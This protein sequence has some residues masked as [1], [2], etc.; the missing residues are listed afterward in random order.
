MKNARTIILNSIRRYLTRHGYTLAHTNISG[1]EPL[2]LWMSDTGFLMIWDKICKKTMIDVSRAYM[3]YQFLLNVCHIEGAAAEI[4]VW[5]GGTAQLISSLLYH[6][7][8]YLFDTFEG[9]PAISPEC[10][11]NYHCEGEFGDTSYED[12]KSLFSQQDY[13]TIIKGV[14]PGSMENG[15]TYP[16]KFCFVHVDVDLYQSAKDCCRHFY[17]LL[18]PGGV[19]IFDDYGFGTCPGVRQAVD[20]FFEGKHGHFYLPTG[21][22]VVIKAGD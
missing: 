11:K 8:I 3:I 13:V 12:V 14:F 5:R 1:V 4:G 10:D 7:K 9:L 6:K 19:M 21:Q 2:K 16:S 20:E 18:V 17:P 22:Y 15:H